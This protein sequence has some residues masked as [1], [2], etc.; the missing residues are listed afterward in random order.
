MCVVRGAEL[1]WVGNC[2]VR[3][4]GSRRRGQCVGLWRRGN[5]AAWE[6]CVVVAEREGSVGGGQWGVC[7][8]GAGLLSAGAKWVGAPEG[9]ICL[10]AWANCVVGPRRGELSVGPWARVLCVARAG[11]LSV[12]RGMFCVCARSGNVCR[13]GNGV[14][15]RSGNVCR[16][17]G[18]AV[19]ERN[20]LRVGNAWGVEGMVVGC[21][22]WCVWA[23]IDVGV[24]KVVDGNCLS[25]GEVFWS[26]IWGCRGGMWGERELSVGVGKCAGGEMG[27]FG[28]GMCVEGGKCCRRGECVW[29]GKFVCGGWGMCVERELLW[30]G[31]ECFLVCVCGGGAGN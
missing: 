10:S 8:R 25:R 26:G 20:C 31:G 16:G 6:M 29:S 17:G 18:N 3:G 14:C 15:A 22:E 30:R 21:G 5:C 24:G 1:L 7:V 27:L 23:G 12:G 11:I 4:A 9:G 28:V 2:G 13:R 19:C